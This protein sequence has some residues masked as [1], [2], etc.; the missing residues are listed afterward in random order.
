MVKDDWLVVQDHLRAVGRDPS[1]LTFAHTQFVHVSDAATTEAA[2]AEQGP[3][4]AR[5]MGDHRSFED[6]AASY[7]LGTVEDIQQRLADLAAVGLQQIIITPV[8][9]DLRQLDLLATHVVAPFR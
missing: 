2:I 4:F 8:T 5:V 9:D 1:T 7:L 3:L 6:L